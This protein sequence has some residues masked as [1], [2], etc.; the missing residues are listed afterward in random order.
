MEG[1][2]AAC[3]TG[4]ACGALDPDDACV[5]DCSHATLDAASG[6]YYYHDEAGECVWERPTERA[7]AVAHLPPLPPA[8]CY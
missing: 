6:R 5:A 2:G 4:D 3:L 7:A 8:C 1:G